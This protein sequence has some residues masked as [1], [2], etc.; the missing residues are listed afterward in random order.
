[1]LKDFEDDLAEGSTDNLFVNVHEPADLLSELIWLFVAVDTGKFEDTTEY[2]AINGIC[3]IL[4][5]VNLLRMINATRSRKLIAAGGLRS[6][7]G[8]RLREV[9]YAAQ[10][11]VFEDVSIAY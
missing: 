4:L 3:W 7:R 1:M 11:I 8:A 6:T 9:V 2:S 5:C 10:Q